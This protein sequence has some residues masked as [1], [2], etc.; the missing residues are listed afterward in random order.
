MFYYCNWHLLTN[1]YAWRPLITQWLVHFFFFFHLFLT[2]HYIVPPLSLLSTILNF[3]W[4]KN[5]LTTIVW[6]SAQIHSHGGKNTGWATNLREGS[7]PNNFLLIWMAAQAL[8]LPLKGT[9]CPH[10]NKAHQVH[11]WVDG[12]GMPRL[13][14]STQLPAEDDWAG[15]TGLKLLILPWKTT[16]SFCI[17]Q[18]MFLESS[19]RENSSVLFILYKPGAV[20]SLR[21][22][23][24]CTTWT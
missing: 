9:S 5:H 15:T 7:I 3:G 8:W 19:K 23:N 6:A 16:W 24:G 22:G 2:D 4:F 1:I 14:N 13:Q 20:C 17:T 12:T 21:S 11:L 10:S 18:W